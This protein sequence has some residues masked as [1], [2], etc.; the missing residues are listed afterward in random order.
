MAKVKKNEEIQKTD[1]TPEVQNATQDTAPVEN[2]EQ[3]V[4]GTA[5]GDMPQESAAP[6]K[7]VQPA[8]EKTEGSPNPSEG[9]KPDDF[10]KS[11]NSAGPYDD[12]AEST[13]GGDESLFSIDAHALRLNVPG[14]WHAAACRLNGWASGKILN[15][16]EYKNGLDALQNRRQGG[17]R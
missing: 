17:G 16:K 12:G 5:A 3:Q 7:N 1:Q 15:E 6:A 11:G 10:E 4:Q 13:S 9:G 2:A 14:W 8:A